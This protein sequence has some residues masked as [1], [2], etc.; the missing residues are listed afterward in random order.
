M[1]V[2]M[3]MTLMIVWLMYSDE[4]HGYRHSEVTT[5]R[6]NARLHETE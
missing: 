5:A 4:C 1:P 2:T 3:A 6:H